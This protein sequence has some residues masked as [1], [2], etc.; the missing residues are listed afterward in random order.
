MNLALWIV[1]IVL[2]VAFAAIGALKTTRPKNKLAPMMPWVADF[3]PAT[4]RFIG[5]VE[6]LAA[7]GLIGPAVTGVATMLV[8]AAAVGLAVTM[9]LAAVVH[10]RRGE[11]S[12]VVVNVVLLALAGFVAWGRFGAYAF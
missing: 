4:V 7:V 2:A 8:P 1:Q 12:A 9:L 3:S 11:A 10:V 5:A 6:L